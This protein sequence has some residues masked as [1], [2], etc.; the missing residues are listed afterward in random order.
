[1]TNQ[2]SPRTNSQSAKLNVPKVNPS[3]RLSPNTRILITKL[4]HSMLRKSRSIMSLVFGK[5]KAKAEKGHPYTDASVSHALIVI[6]LEYFA[7]GLLTVPVINVLA[8]T[9]PTNKFLMNGLVLG[10]KGLLSFLSAPL[11]GALSDV[12]GRKSFLIL[13]VLCTCMPIPCLKISPW[14]YFSLFSLSG[15]FSVT[16]SVI[17]AYVADI[18]EKQ[19]RSSA[20][21]LVSATFAASLVTSPAL[22]AY[23][24]ETY[25]DSMVVLLATIV[26]IADVLFIVIFVPESLPSRRSAG[27]A[28]ILSQEV[29]N[30]QS[31]DP[32]GS[33]RIVWEDKLV[34]QL[35]TIVFLSYLPES[36]QFSCFFVYLKLVVG[37]SPEAVA[38]Y[39]GLVG[40]LSVVAQTGLLLLLTNKFGTKHTITLG[41]LFQLVQLTW[42]GLGAQYWMM[43]SAGVLAAMSS[44]TYPSISAF[45]SILSDKD[46]QGT[47]Q[48]VITG[49]RG[50]CTGF[51][52][53][54][55]GFVFYL[56]D[57]D[58]EDEKAGGAGHLVAPLPA[59]MTGRRATEKI[60]APSR[61]E[62]TWVERAA[63]D[64]Q[65][66]PGPPFL[67]GAMMVLFAL[68]INSTLPQTPAPSK[69][70]R[71]SPTHSRQSSDTARLLSGADT[72]PH[73]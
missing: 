13:T 39:I 55:F 48:G 45:V 62:S 38:M 26:S 68:L 17:L 4:E 37:F 2:A 6:F 7:W 21:G 20:Y 22:G 30:W 61:N 1:M 27:A 54:L 58:L 67:I 47:V 43:W 73:C 59:I 28:P 60:L 11:V 50:L 36:G 49:I 51:G 8:E 10:V 32:F 12:W 14:W 65:F 72:S 63:F 18:T 53:A 69:Y 41:L 40:I 31:A 64:W 57:V 56:F 24:S 66:I 42:Y 23:I 29:F 71:R 34:L 70:F 35:A 33:L 9:F 25:G 16:F 19:E 46:K 3:D 44:I 5:K 52:P 15:L